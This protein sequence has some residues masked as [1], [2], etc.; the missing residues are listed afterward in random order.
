M[1]ELKSLNKFLF[2]YKW[3]LLLGVIFIII[4]NIFAILP[5]ILIGKSFDSIINIMQMSISKSDADID[6]VKHNLLVYGI[7]VIIASILKGV[8]TFFMRQTIIIMSRL[9]EYDLKNEIYSKYQT[10]S[11][12]FYKKNRTGDMMNR[13]SEDVSHVRLYLGPALMYSINLITLIIIVVSNMISINL[14]LTLIT[15]LPLPILV[16]S[17]H[18]VSSKINIQS[19]KVQF[20]LAK[21]STFVQE[22]FSGIRI[23][24]SYTREK[25]SSDIFNDLSEK[26]RLKSV[27][28]AK[29]NAAFYPLLV[30]LISISSTL[31]I[32][33]GGVK[34]INNE[35]SP[36]VIGEFLIYINMLTW[37]VA[38]IGWVTSVIQ[39]ADASQKRINEFLKNDDIIKNNI[40]TPTY[41]NGDIEFKNVSYTYKQSHIN[42]IKNVSFSLKHGK[43][44]AIIGSTGAGKSTI[45][46]LITRLIEADSGEI[47]IDNKPIQNTNLQNLR[48][49]IALIPQDAFLFSDTIKNNI[50]F[51]ANNISDED[52][53]NV[54]KAVGI[55]DE[56][57]SFPNKYNT[58]V[59][60]R[61]ITL[62]GGQKQRLTI[63]RALI[64]DAKTIIFDDSLSAVDSKTEVMILK[65]IKSFSCSKSI[66]FITHRVSTAKNTDNIMVIDNGE[67]CEYG[68]HL[69]LIKSN[70]YYYNLTKIQS[71]IKS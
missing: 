24:K 61:G 16:Y 38:T 34:A 41:I 52:I 9:I 43:S 44:L 30:L 33:Y 57:N 39:R 31:T 45:A 27:A 4:S 46:N 2:K 58:F 63:A 42:A 25:K 67:V 28:L 59:G 65:N 32:Y 51:G 35:I 19:E 13:I 14:E 10:L 56:I 62:S 21:I 3:R 36:G 40:L 50:S 70:G 48:K 7:I 8:F 20:H 49:S 1:K 60:E 17:V 68:Q 55:H 12:D 6:N 47:L 15:L 69:Q 54:A 71:N 26:Y 23:L 22:S 11:F 53:I 66:I 64:S 5:P 18:K 37:P 29:T